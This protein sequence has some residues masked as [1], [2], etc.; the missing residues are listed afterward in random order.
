MN[1]RIL[2]LC[3]LFVNVINWAEDSEQSIQQDNYTHLLIKNIDEKKQYVDFF[4]KQ[5]EDKEYLKD[6]IQQAIKAQSFYNAIRLNRATKF[7]FVPTYSEKYKNILEHKR[8]N[9]LL[10]VISDMVFNNSHIKPNTKKNIIISE[11][12]ISNL[13]LLSKK[14]IFEQIT[15]D[16][17][18]SLDKYTL[19]A[20]LLCPTNKKNKIKENRRLLKILISNPKI[21]K[22]L[23]RTRQMLQ[24]Y[25]DF[26]LL[27][28]KD[29]SCF[30]RYNFN[31]DY[32]LDNFLEY[33]KTEIKAKNNPDTYVPQKKEYSFS[34]N[35]V[36]KNIIEIFRPCDRVNILYLLIKKLNNKFLSKIF[37]KWRLSS[38]FFSI[39]GIILG[40]VTYFIFKIPANQESEIFGIMLGGFFCTAGYI[41]QSI[42]LKD[43]TFV[44][45]LSGI[46]Y[47][48][49]G[50]MIF[51]LIYPILEEMMKHGIFLPVSMGLVAYFVI[52]YAWAVVALLYLPIMYK[53]KEFYRQ[54]FFEHIQN[55]VI[56]NIKGYLKNMRILY[57]TINKNQLLHDNFSSMLTSSEKLFSTHYEDNDNLS[58]KQKKMFSLLYKE[59]PTEND[60][61]IFL[62]LFD[63]N[64]DMFIDIIQEQ[65]YISTYLHSANKVFSGKY[66]ISNFINRD[67]QYI[68]IKN[69]R[70]M[71]LGDNAIP[72]DVELGAESADGFRN[73][74][75]NGMNATGKTVMIETIIDSVLTAQSLGIAPGKQYTATVF[76]NIF[77]YFGADTDI[78][79]NYSRFMSEMKQIDELIRFCNKNKNRKILVGCDEI[80]SGTDPET[81]SALVYNILVTLMQNKNMSLLSAT[82]Y[83]CMRNIEHD[84]P[85]LKCGNYMLMVSHDSNG[86]LK[87][88]RKLTRGYPKHSLAYDII[89]Y[90]IRKKIIKPIFQEFINKIPVTKKNFICC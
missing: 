84:H 16:I 31:V 72:N 51:T 11:Q 25:E 89:T 79:S 27:F 68:K 44:N 24:N 46:S 13:S 19:G 80:C 33:I 6:I 48:C 20:R 83:S 10:D 35:L 17:E 38:F 15:K 61:V 88:L 65:A 74:I 41:F 71:M 73:W 18:H 43:I 75:F 56:P 9:I 87:F 4:I 70:H 30:D 26:L 14:G 60:I 55:N 76:D 40:L 86:N 90:M 8:N 77:T 34:N 50:L 52:I 3:I 62:Y 78:E 57:S 22:Q 23:I 45:I 36:T 63:Q 21:T 12:E 29:K 69:A 5:T 28:H 64:R 42:N 85:E 1:Y 81:A 82:H 39:A 67:K 49:C 32:D 2:K 53:K 58:D 7:N 37:I 66:C 59:D 54:R 47:I